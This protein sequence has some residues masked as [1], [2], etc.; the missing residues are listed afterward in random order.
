MT[1][2]PPRVDPDLVPALRADLVAAGYTVAGVTELLG[3]MAT[4]ALDRDQALPAQRVTGASNAPGATL[5]RLFA[6][7]D[8]VDVAEAAAALP[9][10]GVEGAVALGLVEPEGDAVVALCDLRPHSA[11]GVDWWVASDLGE[12]ATRRPLRENHVLGIGGASTTLASW[13]PRPHVER[14]LDLGTGSGVQALHLEGHADQVVVTDLSERALAFARFNAALD[15]ADWDVRAG[16][17]LDR[18][19]GSASA[20][21]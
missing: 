1:P 4:A 12:V 14:A 21:W 8:P 7:G 2:N 9:T 16:S 19:R 10:L 18:W 3:P 15:E 13:T 20:S 6:L 11:D 5:V 17:M